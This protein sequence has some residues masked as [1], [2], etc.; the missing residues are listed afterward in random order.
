MALSGFV[1][2]EDRATRLIKTRG[3]FVAVIRRSPQHY[4]IR[5]DGVMLGY[6]TKFKHWFAER[7]GNKA[8]MGPMGDG[9]RWPQRTRQDAI[10]WLVKNAA[11]VAFDKTVNVGLAKA[12]GSA[13]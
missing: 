8:F 10:E 6:V 11:S 5:R 13:P 9:S 1:S 2:A 12:A 3:G 4:E 7:S